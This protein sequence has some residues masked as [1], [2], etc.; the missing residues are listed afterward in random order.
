MA[1]VGPWVYQTLQSVISDLDCS[2]P[3]SVNDLDACQWRVELVF[4]ELLAREA[5]GETISSHE[6]NALRLVAEA[7]S[8][9]SQLVVSENACTELEEAALLADGRVG[10]PS[11]VPRDQ[12]EF[13]I[14]S[15][16][17]VPEIASLFNMSVSTVRR[18]MLQHNLTIRQ[19]DTDMTWMQ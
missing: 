10:R 19:T 18:R 9:L 2:A 12:L 15:G 3:L 17:S 11:I 4:R 8:Y 6:S 1:S 16:F 13:L 7:H 5:C 14:Q